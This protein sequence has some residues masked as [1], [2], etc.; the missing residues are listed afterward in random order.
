MRGLLNN[1]D[2]LVELIDSF[3]KVQVFTITHVNKDLDYGT[4]FGIL[5]FG[6]VSKPR[7]NGSSGGIGVGYTYKVN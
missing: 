7:Q 5:G 6:F 3:E 4:L 1:K 2:N